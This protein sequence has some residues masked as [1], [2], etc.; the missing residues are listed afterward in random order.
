MGH[1]GCSF[2]QLQQKS[3]FTDSYTLSQTYLEDNTVFLMLVLMCIPKMALS[4]ILR[5]TQVLWPN[6]A[7]AK[8]SQEAVHTCKGLRK[9]LHHPIADLGH[10]WQSPRSSVDEPAN[11]KRGH[12]A[13]PL[14]YGQPLGGQ[15]SSRN[16]CSYKKR[17]HPPYNKTGV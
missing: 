6:L 8:I 2:L 10:S 15:T 1:S 11:C 9:D 3:S 7:Q 17:M 14:P 16:S 12:P 13:A 5:D 4:N